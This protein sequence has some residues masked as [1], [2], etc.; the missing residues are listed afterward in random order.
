MRASIHP[1]LDFHRMLYS[2]VGLQSMRAYLGLLF[3]I[4]LVIS[5]ILIQE[6]LSKRSVNC[7]FVCYRWRKCKLKLNGLTGSSGHRPAE[8]GTTGQLFFKKCGTPRDGCVCVEKSTEAP[9]V[10]GNDTRPHFPRG[11]VDFINNDA[12]SWLSNL[13]QIDK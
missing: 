4:G 3:A 9:V 10:Q 11:L 8:A 6:S 5:C 7:G 13:V 2:R 12:Q 1:S